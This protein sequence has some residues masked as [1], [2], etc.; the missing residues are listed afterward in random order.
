MSKP[1]RQRQG[2][3][4]A[5]VKSRICELLAQT[6][7]LEAS[8]GA[9]GVHPRTAY[10]HMAKDPEFKKR[11]EEARYC[12]MNDIE[13]EIRRRGLTGISK[14][15][16]YQGEKVGEE[17][18]Y[19]DKLLLALAKA[20]SPARYAERQHVFQEVHHTHEN[21]KE[22]LIQLLQSEDVIEGEYSQI[23][24]KGDDNDS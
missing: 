7:N 3:M 5:E 1:P 11:I 17:K 18:Q 23:T 24:D 20:N 9:A 16:Y 10:Q 8:A 15:I 6:G 2:K 4:T 21:A 14:P 22:K 13:N 12:A 19:S